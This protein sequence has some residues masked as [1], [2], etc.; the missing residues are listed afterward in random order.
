MSSKLKVHERFFETIGSCF[1]SFA[2]TGEEKN[3]STSVDFG[4]DSESSC[5]NNGISD[6]VGGVVGMGSFDEVAFG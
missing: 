3:A 1:A 5:S 4:S 6:A 2:I